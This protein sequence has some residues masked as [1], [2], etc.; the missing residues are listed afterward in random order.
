L[1]SE[2]FFPGGPLGELSKLLPEG[3]SKVVISFSHSKSRKQIF[4]LKFPNSR[5]QVPSCLP[6]DA[7]ASKITIRVQTS[8]NT[9]FRPVNTLLDQ[10]VTDYSMTS[11]WLISKFF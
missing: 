8:Q 10:Q 1:A 11:T 6:S 3:E 7:H 9:E 2:G 4:L 5:G